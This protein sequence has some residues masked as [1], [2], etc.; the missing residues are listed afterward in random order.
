MLWTEFFKMDVWVKEQFNGL[1]AK[2]ILQFFHFNSAFSSFNFSAW[3]FDC[4][5]S[6]GRQYQTGWTQAD[7]VQTDRTQ[8]S[9]ARPGGDLEE[10]LPVSVVQDGRR[11][12]LVPAAAQR[13]RLRRRETKQRGH[14]GGQH[15][16][17]RQRGLRVK[18]CLCDRSQSERVARLRESEAFARGTSNRG[19]GPPLWP[20]PCRPAAAAAADRCSSTGTLKDKAQRPSTGTVHAG[21]D[22]KPF[23]SALYSK[24]LTLLLIPKIPET[25]Q[26]LLIIIIMSSSVP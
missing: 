4:H 25:K 7:G 26:K 23:W 17:R 24:T 6:A 15:D 14:G 2:W 3:R 11:R 20:L 18:R 22:V 8:T 19:R 16:H 9:R 5:G 13:W 10:G 12:L 1:I 21:S